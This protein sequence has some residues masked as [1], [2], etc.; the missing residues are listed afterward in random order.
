MR[1]IDFFPCAR[2]LRAA[3]FISPIRLIS[4]SHMP[5]QSGSATSFRTGSSP[6]VERG[7]ERSIEFFMG[8]R[9]LFG[10]GQLGTCPR[11]H[12]CL[13]IPESLLNIMEEMHSKKAAEWTSSN[14]APLAALARTCK[15]FHLPAIKVLWSDLPGLAPISYLIPESDYILEGGTVVSTRL[16]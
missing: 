12:R 11:M 14:A 9:L 2:R 6:V 4:D 10:P 8:R 16:I 13:L 1:L 5:D 15:A 3:S 7:L